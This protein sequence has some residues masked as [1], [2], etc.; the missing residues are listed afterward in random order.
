MKTL[1]QNY[2]S[3]EIFIE[4]LPEPKIRDDEILVKTSFSAVSLG[5]ESSMINLSKKSIIKKAID[6]PDLVKRVLDKAK[7]TSFYRAKRARYEN[8]DYKSFFPSLQV[9]TLSGLFY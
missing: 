3:G 5:T 8:R 9:I 2:S 4:N 1:I 7:Q 6:R